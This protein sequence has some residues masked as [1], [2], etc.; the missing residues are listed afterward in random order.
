MDICLLSLD[1]FP[2][3]CLP[4]PII[5]YNIDGTQNQKGTICWK[6]RTVLTF[7]DYLDPIKLMI[8]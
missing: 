4:D 3:I 7:D 1:N 6:A 8:L 5:A 2:P